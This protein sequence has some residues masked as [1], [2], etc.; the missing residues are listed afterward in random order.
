MVLEKCKEEE[1]QAQNSCIVGPNA[2][3]LWWAH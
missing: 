3:G 1:K 2:S